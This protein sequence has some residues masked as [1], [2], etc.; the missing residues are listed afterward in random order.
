MEVTNIKLTAHDRTVLE[1]LK[2]AVDGLAQYLGPGYEIVLHSL[3]D[4]EHSAIRVIHGEHTGRREGAPITKLALD[5]LSRIEKG[6]EKDYIC[7]NSTNKDGKP[8]HSTTIAIRGENNRIIGLLCMNFYIDTPLSM[9]IQSIYGPMTSSVLSENYVQDVKEMIHEAVV[10]TAAAVD[11]EGLAG[12]S[13]RNREIVK[14]L[15]SLG[16]FSIKD[17][18]QRVADELSL[19]KNTIYLHLRNCKI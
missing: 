13:I 10:K 7:Y 11:S 1:A 4:L 9:M 16:I 2:N 8:L 17:A 18:V 15:Y 6:I 12:T 5:M 19:S 3:E 14:R